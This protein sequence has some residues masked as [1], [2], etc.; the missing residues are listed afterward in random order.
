VNNTTTPGANDIALTRSCK[1]ATLS[2]VGNSL[3]IQAKLL[4]GGSGKNPSPSY[5]DVL[6]VTVTPLVYSDPGVSDC[7]GL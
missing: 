7:A 5:A 6:T 2:T 1:R 4:Q 3:P